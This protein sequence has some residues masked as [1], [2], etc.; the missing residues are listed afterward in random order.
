[1]KKILSLLFFITF[2][3]VNAQ[4]V[5]EINFENKELMPLIPI[6]AGEKITPSLIRETVANLYQTGF[7]YNVKVKAEETEGGVIVNIETI[8]AK[9]FG[10]I[11]TEGKI[12]IK[13]RR[14]K[15]L[16]KEFY[17][18]GE[19]YRK[20]KLDSFLQTVREKFK[21]L[22]YP[23]AEI[24]CAVSEKDNIIFPIVKIN[25]GKPLIV[26]SIKTNNKKL[27]KKFIKIREG[28]VYNK[29]L[30]LHGIKKLKRYLKEKHFLNSKVEY[31]ERIE[32]NKV[33]LEVQIKKGKKFQ[34]KSKN[35]KI[36]EDEAEETC[37]FLKAGKI[38]DSTVKLTE[39]NLYFKALKMGYSDPKIK[40]DITNDF[41]Y[42]EVENPEKKEIKEI[43]VES[44]IP[45]KLSKKFIYFN[46]L[47]KS[48]IYSEFSKKLSDKGYLKPSIKFDYNRETKVLTVKVS[49]GQ[50]Y[51][52]GKIKLQSDIKI[53][54]K[55]IQD[56]IKQGEIFDKEKISQTLAVLKSFLVG[57]GYFDPQVNI[58]IEK[59]EKGKIPITILVNA[60]EKKVLEDI[61]VLGNRKIKKS[62]ILRFAGFK[63]GE[64]IC[65]YCMENF[66]NR[67]E[68]SGLFRKVDL[69]LIEKGK[70]K[71]VLLVKVSENKLYSFSYAIG[72]N[73]DEGVRFTAKIRKRYLFNTFLTGM[74]IFRISSKRAQ[75][76]FTVSGEKHFL[77]SIYFT[78]EDKD[79]Y[80]FSRFGFSLSYRGEL[81][82]RLKFVESIEFTKNNLT[83]VNIPV[84]EIE[85]ELQP[86]Y[87][88]GFRSSILYDRRDNILFPTKGFFVSAN[89]FPAYVLNDDEFFFKARVKSGIYFKNF[90]FITTIGKIFTK[91][92]YT[93]PI[94]QRF[95]TGG[96]TNLRISSFEK[97]GPQFSTGVAKGGQFLFVF[98][99]EYKYHLKDIYY[100]TFF[101]DIG[102]VWEDSSDFSFSSC[103]K[104][105][106]IGLMVKTPIGPIK[107]QLAHNLDKDTFPSNYKLVFSLGTTF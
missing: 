58:K 37:A 57:E 3:S 99:G 103:I 1:M 94:P 64:I 102:N 83:N 34:I 78:I 79:D 86:D 105:A 11:K 44:D 107:I 92:G 95:F 45:L 53:P 31:K 91:N 24:E 80:K 36:D 13:K 60:G 4:T 49:K 55:V 22:G 14:L 12:G 70:N 18:K 46:K 6:K 50:L 68:F 42:C 27:Y 66:K 71:A 17:P 82:S 62:D 65:R 56:T 32:N 21:E 29:E 106:G 9:F 30:F 93:V 59:P 98:S 39:K 72:L 35:I 85:K 89:L 25:C 52:I 88:V 47:T 63:K 61:V 67:L 97:A 96:S 8:P 90:E 75:G 69:K 15:K 33:F 10:K 76:Y 87:T 74:T 48:E 7:F 81:F 101:A 2:F 20:E 104:D 28:K 40:I 43:E 54:E 19:M 100:L 16:Y 73:S 26:A 77:S 5:K 51:R 41:L 23:N 38:N 84:E